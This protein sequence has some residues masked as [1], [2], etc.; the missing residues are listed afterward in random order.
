MTALAGLPVYLDLASV[1]N[2]GESIIDTFNAKT[3]GWTDEQII[4]SLILLNLAGGECVDDLHILE[5]D[6]G[7]CRILRRIEL[8]DL[9]RKKR[10]QKEKRGEKRNIGQSPPL[11][12]LQIPFCLIR[13]GVSPREKAKLLSL[14]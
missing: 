13:R 1:L 7:F 4:L 6:Q 9:S 5:A 11:C 12:R 14:S 2:L 10:R 3:Q 8:K